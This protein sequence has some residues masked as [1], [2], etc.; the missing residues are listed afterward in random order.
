M[1]MYNY[2]LHIYEEITLNLYWILTVSTN[3]TVV[4]QK[5][6]WIQIN[7]NSINEPVDFT[8]NFTIL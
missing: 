1:R 2:I 7:L 5:T 3:K 4:L 8:N 6:L